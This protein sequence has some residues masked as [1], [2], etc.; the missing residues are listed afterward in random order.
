MCSGEAPPNC[1]ILSNAFWLFVPAVSDLGLKLLPR[2]G[3][4]EFLFKRVQAKLPYAFN[5][6]NP[7]RV[8]MW[9]QHFVFSQNESFKHLRKKSVV[10]VQAETLPH[11]NYLNAI[12][13]Q[14]HLCP[15]ELYQQPVY[16][17]LDYALSLVQLP[18]FLVL[19]DPFC[20]KFQFLLEEGYYVVNP[21]NFGK[22]S[23]F[24]IIYPRQ[25]TIWDSVL[26]GQ[27]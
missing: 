26:P 17:A 7:Q 9:G 10:P 3:M 2:K 25:G 1:R 18:H 23:Q 5:C 12:L 20:P 13:C 27:R 22:S 11:E 21:G 19:S 4:P 16:W 14:K 8:S 6:E 24:V 15:V